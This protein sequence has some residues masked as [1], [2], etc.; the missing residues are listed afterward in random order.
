MWSGGMLL[1]VD[2]SKPRMGDIRVDAEPLIWTIQEF[3][4]K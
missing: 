1:I 4:Q 2:L 3:D